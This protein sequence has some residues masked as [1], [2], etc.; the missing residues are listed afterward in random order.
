MFKAGNN[1]AMI[2]INLLGSEFYHD[3]QAKLS[4]L[5]DHSHRSVTKSIT[6]GRKFCSRNT[7]PQ[8]PVCTLSQAAMASLFQA[9]VGSAPMPP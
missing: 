9:A 7:I 3:S 8:I 4:D 2:P 5:Y 1:P 6:Y